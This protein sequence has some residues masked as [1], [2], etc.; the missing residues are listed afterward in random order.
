VGDDSDSEL[1]PLPDSSICRT[2]HIGIREFSQ[3][4]VNCPLR[5]PH[6]VSFGDKFLCFHPNRR[7]FEK[8]ESE[9]K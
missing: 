7:S 6:A 2:R 3:C 5:C 4:L 8:P 1:K 9:G